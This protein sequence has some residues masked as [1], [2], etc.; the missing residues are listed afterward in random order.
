MAKP[1]AVDLRKRVV[2]AHLNGEGTYAELAETF[3]IGEA[4]VSRWLRLQREGTL[5]PK[6]PP[7]RKPKLGAE[8]E[9]VVRRLVA[10]TP[11]ATLKELVELVRRETAIVVS[12]T[13]LFETLGRLGLTRK[14]KTS[15]R[16]SANATR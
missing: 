8:H 14:K 3:R 11:D 13:T 9:P 4:S 2:D 10:E 5:E 15:T 1:I 16:R 12:V 7:G 6:P